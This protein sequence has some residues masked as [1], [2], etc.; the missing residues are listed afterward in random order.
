M[1]S[2]G[3]LNS[4]GCNTLVMPSPSDLGKL[5][6]EVVF[7]I[8]SESG[9]DCGYSDNHYWQE[10]CNLIE[11]RAEVIAKS[12]IVLMDDQLSQ[13]VTSDQKKIFIT[14]L[15]VFNDFDKLILLMSD[16][17]DLYSFHKSS[18]MEKVY[19]LTFKE[20]FMDFIKFYL[21]EPID[22]DTILAFSRSK[23]V[24]NGKVIHKPLI[25]HLNSY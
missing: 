15:D 7:Y 5:K 24:A 3:I 11:S 25:N 2:I 6:N 20:I 18:L 9:T 1:L 22:P 21:G 4:G 12:D 8:E 14:N 23:I 17:I 19:H 13:A 16:N 10:G